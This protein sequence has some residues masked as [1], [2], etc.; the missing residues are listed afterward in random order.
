[1]PFRIFVK[2]QVHKNEKPTSY[3]ILKHCEP[4]NINQTIAFFGKFRLLFVKMSS[5]D[6]QNN[7]NIYNLVQQE[8]VIAPK[9]PRYS[10][11]GQCCHNWHYW[12]LIVSS[13]FFKTNRAE[14]KWSLFGTSFILKS[15][16]QWSVVPVCN[17][18]DRPHCM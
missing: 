2:L 14:L 15:C 4:A 12:P 18:I 8:E 11:D 7:E 1:M 3:I 16:H 6:D 17:K 5:Y 10:V 9:A 13:T